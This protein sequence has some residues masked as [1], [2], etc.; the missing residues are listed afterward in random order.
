[1]PATS[2]WKQRSNGSTWGDF[3]RD[4]Q[5][6]RINLLTADKVR[7]GAVEVRTG[8][9]FCLSLPLDVPGE[10]KLNPRRHPPKLR[11]TEM[12]GGPY[13]NQA[14]AP[15]GCTQHRRDLR[16]PGQH[17]PAVFDAVGRLGA[18]RLLVRRGWRRRAREGLLQRLA[19][20]RGRRRPRRL[21][22]CRLPLPI[23]DCRLPIA[24]CRLPIADCR[25]PIADCRL[26]IAD[27]RLPIADCR[28]P[29][30]DCRLPA[31]GCGLRAAGQAGRMG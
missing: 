4:D 6:G 27:C 10:A 22:T 29:I 18:C 30:A 31:A 17:L 24:D 3:G 1:M 14:A 11:P 25:L 21:E 2:R 28:L 5:L 7:A 16:R 15:S 23:A 13:M 26:P 19:R 20:T 12:N 8:R 9:A